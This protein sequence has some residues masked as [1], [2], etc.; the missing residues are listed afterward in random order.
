MA[1]RCSSPAEIATTLPRGG[2]TTDQIPLRSDAPPTNPFDD[3]PQSEFERSFLA[4]LSS[5]SPIWTFHDTI[6]EDFVPDVPES[7]TNGS[8]SRLSRLTSLGSRLRNHHL[9]NRSTS[10]RTSI[11]SA[12]VLVRAYS[13][14]R[15]RDVSRARSLADSFLSS[16]AAAMRRNHPTHNAPANGAPSPNT[17]PM[18]EVKLPPISDFSFDGILRAVEPEIQDALDAI[19]EICARSR[20]SMANAHGAHMPPQG[21]ITAP[22]QQQQPPRVRHWGLGIRTDVE[23]MTSVPEVSSSSGS[24]S[25][26]SS[27]SGLGRKRSAMGSLR[28]IMRRDSHAPAGES[29]KERSGQGKDGRSASWVVVE[30]QRHPSIVLV[31]QAMASKKLSLDTVAEVPA[32]E[33]TTLPPSKSKDEPE[34]RRT[35]SW[36][37][38]RTSS[39]QRQAITSSEEPRQSA[40]NLLKGLLRDRPPAVPG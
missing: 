1:R 31:A 17:T 30:D 29:S 2:S 33:S 25:K 5:N 32:Q 26:A 34:G 37:P 4:F 19:A 35:A 7:T 28:G 12:P 14:P 40:E 22:E 9:H 36:M 27:A 23:R 6:Q 11:S 21:E 38:W 24:A 20:M 10:S 15:S 18:T 3:D 8:T 13:G 16:T 39:P